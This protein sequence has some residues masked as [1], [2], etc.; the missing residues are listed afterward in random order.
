MVTVFGF[1]LFERFGALI[2]AEPAI[3]AVGA[4]R[5]NGFPPF[6]TFRER[7]HQ[8]LTVLVLNIL[9]VIVAIAT[10]FE[11]KSNSTYGTG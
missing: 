6:V 3:G 10:K 4:L 5:L 11:S 9:L 7:R 2:E 8:R 1:L